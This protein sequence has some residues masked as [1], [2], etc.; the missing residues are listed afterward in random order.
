M[1]DSKPRDKSNTLVV[2]ISG[3]S[4]SGK[5]TLARLLQRIFCGVDLQEQVPGPGSETEKEKLNTFI[6]HEDD[7]YYPDDQI[8]Y[9]TTKSGERIQDWDTA[10]AIDTNFLA[11]A[12]AYVRE[13]GK[14][15]PRLQSK[16]DQNDESD[17]GVNKDLVLRLR[18]LVSSQLLSTSSSAELRSKPRT[19]AFMEGFLLYSA[20]AENT[21]NNQAPSP[22]DAVQK[23]IHLPIFLP[24][25]YTNVKSRRE[26]RSGY[27]TIGEAPVSEAEGQAES[28]HNEPIDLEAEDDRPPQNFWV[29]PPGYVDDIVWPRYVED[30]AWL[31]V[32]DESVEGDLVARVGEG[33]DVRLDAGVRVAP[34]RGEAGMDAVL[35]WA[36]EEI[37][38]FYTGF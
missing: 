7:F 28:K 5:T 2:G 15:P 26:A 32:A 3:P 35:E 24:A 1:A 14:L 34:G 38:R 22:L 20:P 4:S 17:S 6:I 37:L 31:L 11:Q 8:P 12:L 33:T 36:V 13:H 21:T 25:S 23:Q 9:T 30:H 19:I 16:E 18:D 10:A 29:D 27:V